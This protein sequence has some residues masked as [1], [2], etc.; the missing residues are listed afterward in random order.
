MRVVFFAIRL[1]WPAKHVRSHV[2]HV[3]SV[4]ASVSVLVFADLGL[5][6][7]GVHVNSA[8]VGVGV[9]TLLQIGEVVVNLSLFYFRINFGERY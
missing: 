4:G 3:V 7:H 8:T 6:A 5:R 9:A 2:A 1:V